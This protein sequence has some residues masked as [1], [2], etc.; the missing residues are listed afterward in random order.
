MFLSDVYYFN[1][2]FNR[3]DNRPT[4]VFIRGLF[5]L[6]KCY[7]GQQVLQKW[8]LSDL[9][10]LKDTRPPPRFNTAHV[11]Y[12]SF[13]NDPFIDSSQ[14]QCPKAHLCKVKRNTSQKFDFTTDDSTCIQNFTI[15]DSSFLHKETL[16][17]W[18]LANNQLSIVY[19]NC[20]LWQNKL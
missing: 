1:S 9:Y 8:A 20:Q 2:Y 15:L 18:K 7:W 17:C 14:H 3:L 4:D 6:Q 13:L 5:V 10:V 19:F 11:V 16:T 12:A